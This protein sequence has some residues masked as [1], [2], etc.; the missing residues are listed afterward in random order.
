MRV[1]DM[2]ISGKTLSRFRRF[3]VICATL[4]LVQIGGCAVLGNNFV[5]QVLA[6]TVLNPFAQ[7]V[8]NFF[9]NAASGG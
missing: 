1:C 3:A 6:G 9:Y 7:D 8:F 4:P 5:E 2:R